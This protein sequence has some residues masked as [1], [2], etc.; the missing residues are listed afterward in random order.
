MVFTRQNKERLL[1]KTIITPKRRPITV[2][3]SNRKKALI[4]IYLKMV[5]FSQILKRIKPQT[6]WMQTVI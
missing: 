2:S 6:P 1:P 4:P 3:I 5:P